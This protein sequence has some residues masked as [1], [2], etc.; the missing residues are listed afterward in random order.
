MASV[1]I[2]A[3]TDCRLAIADRRFVGDAAAAATVYYYVVTAV[4]ADGLESVRS[5]SVSPVM[6]I[7]EDGGGSSGCF[8]SYAKMDVNRSGIRMFAVLGV[9]LALTICTVGHGLR[10][11]GKNSFNIPSEIHRYL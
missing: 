3:C 11:K 10:R 2:T 6:D 4:D 5:A 8:I 7:S 1:R 9:S